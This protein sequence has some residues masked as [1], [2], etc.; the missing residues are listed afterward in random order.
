MP[1]FKLKAGLPAINKGL[2]LS[3]IKFDFL[4][5]AHPRGGAHDIGAY[6]F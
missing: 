2:T 1:N 4:D 6:E 3:T 5:V